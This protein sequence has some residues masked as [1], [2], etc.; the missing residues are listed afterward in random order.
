MADVFDSFVIIHSP[1]KVHCCI[2][3]DFITI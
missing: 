3:P 2:M 1:R